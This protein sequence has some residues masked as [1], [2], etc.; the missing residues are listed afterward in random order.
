MGRFDDRRKGLPFTRRLAPVALTR[1]MHKKQQ[2]SKYGKSIIRF[3]KRQAL[4]AKPYDGTD[5]H[6]DLVAIGDTD[7]LPVVEIKGHE[8][9]TKRQIL[10][11]ARGN[12]V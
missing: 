12:N 11:A 3:R 8:G 5:L 7:P 1:D 10:K 6:P 4:L 9:K 2:V